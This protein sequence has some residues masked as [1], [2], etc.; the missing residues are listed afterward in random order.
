MNVGFGVKGVNMINKEMIEKFL[1]K[2]SP[3]LEPIV[4]ENTILC[5]GYFY[6]RIKF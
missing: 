4:E 5:F 3:P 2:T 6:K 1:G